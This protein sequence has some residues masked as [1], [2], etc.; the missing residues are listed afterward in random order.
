[1]L[2]VEEQ[3]RLEEWRAGLGSGSE[4][5]EGG[6]LLS[7]VREPNLAVVGAHRSPASLVTDWPIILLVLGEA[8]I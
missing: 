8:M 5:C 3:V 6:H 1:M 4:E 2:R 7:R